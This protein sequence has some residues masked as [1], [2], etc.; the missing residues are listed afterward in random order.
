MF[1]AIK[2]K[3]AEFYLLD[4]YY[5]ARKHLEVNA[6]SRDHADIEKI[7]ERI[8]CAGIAY[9]SAKFLSYCKDGSFSEECYFVN[10]SFSGSPKG[11][12]RYNDF[13]KELEV[14]ITNVCNRR[15]N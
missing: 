4:Q 6:A 5:N 9:A 10:N 14:Y 11:F 2:R 13:V 1:K 3:I 12:S 7:C 15:L 8:R